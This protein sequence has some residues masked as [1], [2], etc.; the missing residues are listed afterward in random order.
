MK[1]A[2]QILEAK[3]YDHNEANEIINEE[4]DLKVRELYNVE[5][6]PVHLWESYAIGDASEEALLKDA[7]S[8]T[9][10]IKKYDDVETLFNDMTDDLN[11]FAEQYPAKPI[12][13]DRDELRKVLREEIENAKDFE[14]S[15]WRIPIYVLEDGTVTSGSWLSQ[16]SS[17]PSTHELYGIKTWSMDEVT[18]KAGNKV[19][20]ET[21]LTEEEYQDNLESYLDYLVD[22]HEDRIYEKLEAENEMDEVMGNTKARKIIIE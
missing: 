4:L 11:R 14:W 12:T 18:D 8:N 1:T 6:H 7:E 17:S 15:G 19:E 10:P 5:D 21:E 20:D 3:G 13:V 2:E 22:F 16:G 9:T